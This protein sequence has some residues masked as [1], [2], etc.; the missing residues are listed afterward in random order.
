MQ[1]CYKHA[2]QLVSAGEQP[3][4]EV[5][6][7]CGYKWSAVVRPVGYSGKFSAT[8]L[9]M[10]CGSEMNIELMGNGSGGHSCSQHA[11]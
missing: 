1:T 4:V 8:T 10:A 5:S 9:E 11:L 6:G 3:G 2:N 7:W